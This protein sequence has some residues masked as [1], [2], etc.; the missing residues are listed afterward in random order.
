MESQSSMN[1]QFLILINQIIEENLEDENFSVEELAQKAGLSRSMLHRKLVKLTG[2][3][4]SDYIMEIR[5]NR[6]KEFLENDV[7]T[8]SEIAYKVGFNNLSYF[9]KAFRR[10]REE[11]SLV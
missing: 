4:A 2:K 8:V 1:D 5:L 9:S 6:A 11:P 3:S 10:H 7:A